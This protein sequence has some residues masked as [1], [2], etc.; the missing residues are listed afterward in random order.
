M[1]LELAINDHDK[2]AHERILDK[3]ILIG[4]S[5]TFWYL[6]EFSTEDLG[7]PC[8]LHEDSIWLHKFLVPKED[9]M[10]VAMA[11]CTIET[12]LGTLSDLYNLVHC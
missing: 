8:V 11:N 7:I 3:S 4:N 10:L 6:H 12:T 5:F 9:V 1:T 2:L